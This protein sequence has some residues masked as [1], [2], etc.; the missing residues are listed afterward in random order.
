MPHR[1]PGLSQRPQRPW[2]TAE[3]VVAIAN[4]VTDTESTLIITAAYTGMRW[5]ELA[6]RVVTGVVFAASLGGHAGLS[7]PAVSV[8]VHRVGC[9]LAALHQLGVIDPLWGPA[10]WKIK[11]RS[12][13]ASAA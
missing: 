8:S 4:R 1:R 6:G 3:Q 5:G 10:A 2:A 7:R 12:C 13:T 11:S 9:S